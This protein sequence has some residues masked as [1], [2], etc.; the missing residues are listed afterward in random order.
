MMEQEISK[1]IL[2]SFN[3]EGTPISIEPFGNGLINETFLIKTAES[4][5]PDYV[6]QRINHA[7]FQDID[8]LQHNIET[9][10]NHI[11]KKLKAQGETD[12]DRKV[13]RFIQ[14]KGGKTYYR[15]S[16]N[17]YWR[18]SVFINNAKSFESVTPEHAYQ[19][20]KAFGNFENML[21]DLEEQLEETIPDFHNMELRAMQLKDAIDR[22]AAGRLNEV[23]E[24]TEKLNK[25]MYEMCK[26]EQL[27]RAGELRKRVCHCDTK[28]NNMMFDDKGH[29]LCVID[30]DT[31]MPSFVFS[32]YGDFLRSAANA[33]SED[34]AE[35][36]HVKLRKDIIAS[37]TKG[38]IEGTTDFLT[39]TERNMLPFAMTLFP[40]MQCVRF[41][42]DYLDGDVYY[43][44]NYPQHNLDRAKNQYRLY[45]L[46]VAEKE[47]LQHFISA[48]V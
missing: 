39:E 13:L 7:V 25:D 8:L 38:Y 32:D 42:T 34:D 22:N 10:T 2:S 36:D 43:K 24:L 46:M 9:V 14:T 27:Y 45:E 37:Y 15:D 33:T 41:L 23:E 47:N 35:L 5:A 29:L 3:I 28:V 6:L 48:L 1:E 18:I 21:I 30:L 11:R 19:A 17:R 12:I 20:G 26:A 31:V 4:S 40:F 16:K 44:I